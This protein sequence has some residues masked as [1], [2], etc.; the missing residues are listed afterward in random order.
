MN[1]GARIITGIILGAGSV[2]SLVAARYLLKNNKKEE[3][4]IEY[5]FD[6]EDEAE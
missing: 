2:L 3:E 4:V 6:I 1:D 5:P